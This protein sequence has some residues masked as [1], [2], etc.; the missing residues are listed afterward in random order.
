[1]GNST[2]PLRLAADLNS[3]RQFKTEHLCPRE[4]LEW[5]LMH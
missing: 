3:D 5:D 4:R 1:M 2:Q